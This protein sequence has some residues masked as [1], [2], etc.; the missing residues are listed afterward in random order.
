MARKERALLQAT[1]P[2]IC[3]VSPVPGSLQSVKRVCPPDYPLP[4]PPLAGGPQTCCKRCR[5][6]YVPSSDGKL[7]LP[8]KCPDVPTGE[9]PWVAVQ[10]TVDGTLLCVKCKEPTFIFDPATKLC[11]EPCKDPFTIPFNP[12]PKCCAP[13]PDGFTQVPGKPACENKDGKVQDMRCV[14]RKTSQSYTTIKVE[15]YKRECAPAICPPAP[16]LTIPGNPVKCVKCKPPFVV[17]LDASGKPQCQKACPTGYLPCGPYCFST[18]IPAVT[19]ILTPN[20]SPAACEAFLTLFSNC[21]PKC[22]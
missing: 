10:T 18:T 11:Y 19:G 16:V 22:P 12:P 9:A 2:P 13:C 6:G 1:L 5:D 7:C 3:V 15:P 17:Y 8:R 4:I 20:T 14:D 21:I